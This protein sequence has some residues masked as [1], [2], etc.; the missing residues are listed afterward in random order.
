MP[1]PLVGVIA[2]GLLVV[3]LVPAGV[4][5]LVNARRIHAWL[6]ERSWPGVLRKPGLTEVLLI[7][8]VWAVVGV[9]SIGGVAYWGL[10]L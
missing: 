2:F 10:Q 5:L 1:S 6:D 3:V 4:L 7:G 8:A 9:F